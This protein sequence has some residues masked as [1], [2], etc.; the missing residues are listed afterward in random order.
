M[1]DDREHAARQ[2]G[3]HL[4]KFRE[5]DP[6]VL[7]IARGGVETAYYVAD[8]LGCKFDVLIARKLGLPA[9]PEAAFGALAEDGSLYLHPRANRVL[10][11]HDIETVID[12]ETREIDRRKQTYRNGNNIPKLKGRTVILVDDGIATGATLFAAIE[13]CRHQQVNKLIVAAPVSGAD[14][15]AELQSKADEVV[16]LETPHNYRAVS[17]AYNSFE[18]LSDDDVL[19]FLSSTQTT[20]DHQK[21]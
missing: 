19:G 16:I 5:E 3:K 17:M 13:M 20:K 11:K 2:L 21:K 9:Q 6:I 12:R 7:G 8:E 4:E 18:N 10:S 15:E 14:T 1:F